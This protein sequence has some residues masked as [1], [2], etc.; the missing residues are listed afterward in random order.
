MR[1]VGATRASPNDT[2]ASPDDTRASPI[3]VLAVALVA[4][5][6]A[7]G[8]GA[9]SVSSADPS[10]PYFPPSSPSP[11]ASQGASANAAAAPSVGGL[12][13]ISRPDL[14]ITPG[15]VAVRDVTAVC[16]APKH[17]HIQIPY[18]VQLSVY[19][20]YGLPA[21]A[22][23][24][25]GL[26]YLVPLQLGGAVVKANLWPAAIQG[27]GFHQKEQLN[28]RLRLMVCEQGLPLAQAQQDIVSDWYA[29]WIRYATAAEIAA[30]GS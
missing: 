3:P 23:A 7:T 21:T 2:R 1:I 20:S 11:V 27:I 14:R 5:L 13:P 28:Y 15:V 25:Y 6:L 16:Q 8:C 30:A 24:S 26:D 10:A 9:R 18:Y 29:L 12:G 4:V 19:A 22:A 17:T